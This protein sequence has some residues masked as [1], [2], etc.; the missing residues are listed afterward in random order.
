MASRLV[1][2]SLLSHLPGLRLSLLTVAGG[3]A[4]VL[5]HGQIAPAQTG[6]LCLKDALEVELRA[7]SLM[8]IVRVSK[9]MNA[10]MLFSMIAL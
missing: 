9:Q 8:A 10:V 6:R 4:L 2:P 3:F 7:H 5:K 1:L